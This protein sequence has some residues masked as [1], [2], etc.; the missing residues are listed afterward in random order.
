MQ[1]CQYVDKAVEIPF[2][3]PD[4][5]YAWEQYRFDVQFSGSDY[6]HDPVWLNKKKWLEARGSTMVFFP[7]TQTTSSSKIKKL[8]EERLM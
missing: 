8:I 5:D 3:H 7:Y 4:T 6:E 1:S 2:E